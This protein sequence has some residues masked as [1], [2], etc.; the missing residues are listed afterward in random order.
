MKTPQRIFSSTIP[1][2][3]IGTE[4]S[5][6]MLV[7][8]YISHNYAHKKVRDNQNNYN[9]EESS[10]TTTFS[11]TNNSN[12]NHTDG[13]LEIKLINNISTFTFY[14]CKLSHTSYISLKSEQN[15]RLNFTEFKSYLIQLFERAKSQNLIILEFELGKKIHTLKFIEHSKLKNIS[16][17]KLPFISPSSTEFKIYLNTLI[18]ELDQKALKYEKLTKQLKEHI[19]VSKKKYKQQVYTL[20]NEINNIR[21][22]NDRLKSLGEKDKK[23]LNEIKLKYQDITNRYLKNEELLK[24][25]RLENEGNKIKIMKYNENLQD[26]TK[27]QE[28]NKVFKSDIDVA[29][30]I[31]KNLRAEMK[32]QTGLNTETNLQITEL[33]AEV[34]KK[35]ELRNQFEK[36]ADKISK[37]LRK[38]EK[39]N[40]KLEIK[41]KNERTI[42]SRL[43]K[44]L[45]DS[46]NVLKRL[47]QKGE[48]T[49]EMRNEFGN[50][51]GG[52]FPPELNTKSIEG[53]LERLR[54]KRDRDSDSGD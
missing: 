5:A 3:S 42:N 32:T 36:T 11:D 49:H 7:E 22:E 44:Q 33:K 50:K 51:F 2:N 29:N 19:S 18:S 20:T 41:I 9:Y 48:L 12:I 24:E 43:Q 28:E 25:L 6:I 38:T 4:V 53:K 26:I 16:I 14:L 1:M 35:E 8:I 31:I 39:E 27:L 21:I 54:L 30:G 45:E 46:Q 17:L 37:K 10:S 15:L 13:E 23:V 34:L 47:S 52:E 40:K